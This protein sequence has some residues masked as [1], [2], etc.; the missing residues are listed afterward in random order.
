[1]TWG[2]GRSLPVL[3]LILSQ[4]RM[5]RHEIC[6]VPV[7]RRGREKKGREEGGETEKKGREEGGEREKSKR[8]WRGGKRK[9]RKDKVKRVKM[10]CNFCL[11]NM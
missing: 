11:L 3:C 8:K 5:S 9:R 4:N 1:M 2:N 7:Q 6:N 10:Q